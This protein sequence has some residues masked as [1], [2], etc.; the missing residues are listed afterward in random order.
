MPCA[1]KN[2][3]TIEKIIEIMNDTKETLT[4]NFQLG[5]WKSFSR[6]VIKI[7]SVPVLSV[8]MCLNKS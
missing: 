8:V 6:K 1:K 5:F 2:I 7:K 3:I 4:K